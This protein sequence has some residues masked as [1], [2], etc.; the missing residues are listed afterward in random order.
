[1]RN[2]EIEVFSFSEL[3]ESAQQAAHQEWLEG[4]EDSDCVWDG[5]FRDILKIIAEKTGV[6][7][8]GYGYDR[9]SY[10]YR[11]DDLEMVMRPEFDS[12]NFEHDP[13]I[14]SEPTGIRAG[15]I[16][17]EV[18]YDL[19]ESKMHFGRSTKF[20]SKPTFGYYEDRYLSLTEVSRPSAFTKVD[21]C[22]TKNCVESP[23]LYR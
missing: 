16:A 14:A 23:Y 11:I 10:N 20:E 19:V 12:Y 8:W 4:N 5:E 6:S 21:D 18:Y 9:C 17:L 2:V 3:S 22:F 7:L 15:K 13:M 1:M